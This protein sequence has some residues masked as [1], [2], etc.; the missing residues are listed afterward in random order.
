MSS[1]P[2]PSKSPT[3]QPRGFSGTS[4]GEVLTVKRVSFSRPSRGASPLAGG[5][6]ASGSGPLALFGERH[7]TGAS[8][9]YGRVA[10]V[11]YSS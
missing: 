6:R 4:G 3:Y 5:C 7:V 11:E 2:S 1:R 9:G 8:P 10:K